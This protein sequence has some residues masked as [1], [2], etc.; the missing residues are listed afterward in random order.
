MRC[1]ANISLEETERCGD[2]LGKFPS[3]CRFYNDT[4]QSKEQMFERKNNGNGS[5]WIPSEFL[6][7]THGVQ[8]A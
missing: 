4:G 7:N 2:E 1:L 8:N 3:F 5:I 6:L